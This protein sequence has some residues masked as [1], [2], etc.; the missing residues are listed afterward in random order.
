M[1]FFAFA[2]QFDQV[3]NPLLEDGYK[4]D[5]MGKFDCVQEASKAAEL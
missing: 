4:E 1:T 5:A 3:Q 2:C